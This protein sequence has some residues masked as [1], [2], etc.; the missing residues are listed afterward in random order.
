MSGACRRTRIDTCYLW[1]RTIPPLLKVWVE[2]GRDHGGIIFIDD[3]TIS[4]A[5]IGGQVRASPV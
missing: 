4:P 2:A 1:P 3:K 5:D